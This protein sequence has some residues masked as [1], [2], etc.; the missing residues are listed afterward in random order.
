MASENGTVDYVAVLADLE[1]KRSQID[2]AIAGISV[3]LGQAAPPAS[4][5]AQG[6]AGN[7]GGA[8]AEIQPDSF[9]SLSIPDAAKKY[10]GMR[11]RTATTPEIVEALRRGGQ[12]NAGSENYSITVGTVLNRAYTNGTGIVRVSRG[13]WGLAEWYPNKPRKPASKSA[14]SAEEKVK[15]SGAG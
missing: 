1:A 7:S 6:A 9:F 11:K 15:D 4:I 12:Q 8:T 3:M 13:T 14:D 2:A 5:G 10:L